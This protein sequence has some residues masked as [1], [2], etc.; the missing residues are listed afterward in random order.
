MHKLV[1]NVHVKPRFSLHDW[2]GGGFTTARSETN[3]S[4][5]LIKISIIPIFYV[6]CKVEEVKTGRHFVSL[7]DRC[8][9][10]KK[11]PD[12]EKNLT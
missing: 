3:L 5:H 9:P 11:Y 2:G 8:A 10:E 4:D 7:Q 12:S 1:M 6:Q